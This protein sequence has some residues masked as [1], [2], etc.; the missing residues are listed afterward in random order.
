[1][2]SRDQQQNTGSI[3]ESLTNEISENNQAIFKPNIRIMQWNADGIKLRSHELSARLK[4]RDIDICLVQ[5]SKLRPKKDKTPVVDGYIPIYRTDRP[6]IT[7]GGLIIYARKEIVYDKVGHAFKNATEVQC[8]KIKL[9]RKR[10]LYLSNVYVPPP[11]SKG[12]V[13]NFEPEIIPTTDPSII[14]GDFNAHS[15][16]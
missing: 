4:S 9:A 1:M 11:N 14:C 7:F 6:T 8:V 15:P 12:Q 5:E 10:W 13:I 3:Q 16:V 2:W